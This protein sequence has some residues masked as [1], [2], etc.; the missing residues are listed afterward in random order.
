MNWISLVNLNEWMNIYTS[1][2][3]T[4]YL[5]FKNPSKPLTSEFVTIIFML[6]AYFL[7]KFIFLV[8]VF[9]SWYLPIFSWHCSSFPIPPPAARSHLIQFAC[10]PHRVSSCCAEEQ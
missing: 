5:M 3:N 4:N 7:F 2:E 6:Y 1:K 9:A 10:F 8:F